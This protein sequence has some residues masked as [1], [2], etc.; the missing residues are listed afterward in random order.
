MC[1]VSYSFCVEPEQ[2]KVL[3]GIKVFSPTGYGKRACFQSFPLVYDHLLPKC[4][5][6]IIVIV[7]L[8][9]S[10]TK[11]Q[12]KIIIFVDNLSYS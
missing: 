9:I 11:D 8:L 3:K 6:T 12:V 10:I 2:M 7:V 1:L 5:P 4:E